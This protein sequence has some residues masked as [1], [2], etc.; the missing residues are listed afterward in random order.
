MCVA[1]KDM[2]DE[3][4]ISCFA[5]LGALA[6]P[7]LLSEFIRARSL[8]IAE[9]RNRNDDFFIGDHIFNGN[10]S[11]GKGD[12]RFALIAVV[13]FNFQQFLFQDITTSALILEDIFQVRDFN[14][15]PVIFVLDLLSLH[16]C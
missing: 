5:S 4:R 1:N 12:Y 13:I 16:A 14:K 11:I 9:M 2:F 6:S 7:S 15:H 10:F 3:V 8:N